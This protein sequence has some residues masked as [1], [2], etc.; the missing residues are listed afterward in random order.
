MNT[1]PAVGDRICVTGHLSENGR[2]YTGRTGRVERLHRFHRWVDLRI[3]NRIQVA[4]D[5]L[6][7]EP[8]CQALGAGDAGGRVSSPGGDSPAPNYVDDSRLEF[9]SAERARKELQRKIE[10]SR[11]RRRRSAT[12]AR[13]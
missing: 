9:E 6:N 2:I 7:I 5:V 4:V 8:L 12:A 3:G 11:A 1:M 10:K 13:G